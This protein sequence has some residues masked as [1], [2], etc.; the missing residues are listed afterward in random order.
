MSEVKQ[1]KWGV[2]IKGC[3][4]RNSVSMCITLENCPY[5]CKCV[6]M[7]EEHKNG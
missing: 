6:K 1:C 4:F 3:P 7:S 2:T 5:G